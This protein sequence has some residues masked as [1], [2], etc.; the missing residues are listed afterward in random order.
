M[1][2]FLGSLA[3]VESS[4]CATCFYVMCSVL[5]ITDAPGAMVIP[6][7]C[8]HSNAKGNCTFFLCN[9]LGNHEQ[10]GDSSKEHLRRAERIQLLCSTD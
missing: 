10:S 7:H 5:I 8:V 6:E 2:D 9:A 3:F 4:F 1:G